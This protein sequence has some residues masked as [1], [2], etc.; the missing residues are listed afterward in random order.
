V[1]KFLNQFNE[2]ISGVISCFDRMLFKGYLPL[3]WSGAMERLLAREKLLIKD[4]KRFVMKQSECIKSHAE[5][6]AARH[7]RPFLYL[8]GRIR[9]EELVRKLSEQDGVTEGLVCVLRVLEPCQS[10]KM[11]PGEGRPRLVNAQRKCLC[12]YFYFIDR[13]FGLM[14]VR[15]QSWF[16]LVIQICLNGHEWLA[17]KLDKHGIEYR[18]Q[19][20]AFLWI[21]DCERAQK[22]ADRF[23]KKHWPRV[24]ASFAKREFKVRR[25]GK[26][27]GE[28]VLDWFPMAKG[29]A[30]MPR[31][32]EVTLAANRRYLDALSSVK[33]PGD[34]RRRM[35]RLAEPVRTKTRSHRGLNPARQ[36]DVELMAAVMRGEHTIRGFTNADIR[37]HLCRASQD[38]QERR[39]ASQRTGRR[40]QLLHAHGLIARIPRSRRWRVTVNGWAIM[41]TILIHHHHNYPNT[42]AAQA[43]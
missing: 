42:H 25:H 22:L 32:R 4:F 18:K 20:N 35:R 37:G 10:F 8:N 17:R 36:E 2:K 14:H 9:K 3:G 15:I 23:A 12:F 16:P 28:V 1:K 40:L 21:S 43:A 26:R 29:V 33:Q 31:Y 24:L 39:R 13:E 19:D 41:T 11:I 38:K 30:N 34:S 7:E 5:A 6:V 27:K